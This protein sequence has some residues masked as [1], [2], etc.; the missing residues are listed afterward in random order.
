MCP[1]KPPPP[2]APP[3]RKAAVEVSTVEV[4]DR[5]VGVMPIVCMVLVIYHTVPEQEQEQGLE[6]DQCQ[7]QGQGQEQGRD[8]VSPRIKPAQP[9]YQG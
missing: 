6:Q 9:T 2:L 4:K 7:E 1:V 5:G 3:A 8:C